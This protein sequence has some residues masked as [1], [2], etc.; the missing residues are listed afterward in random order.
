[1]GMHTNRLIYEKSPYLLQHAHNPV[2]WRPWGPEALEEARRQ[3]KPIFLSVG[4]STCHWCHVMERESFQDP[5]IAA[6]LNRHFVPIKVDREERP[7]VDRV[8]MSFVQATTG[9]G[10]W[11]LSVFL[12]PELE[13]FFG[14]TYFPPDNRYGRPGLRYV[15]ERIAEAWQADRRRVRSSGAAV[16]AELRRHW[17]AQQSRLEATETVL[18]SGFN[19]FRRIFDPTHGGFGEAPKFPRPAVLSFLLRYWERTANSEALQMALATLRAMARGGLRDQLGGGF[20]RYS[21]DDRWR[22][23][24][25]EKMLYDQAQLVVSYLEAWQAAG[26]EIFAEVARDTLEY[27][28][29]DMQHAEGG[30]CAAEDADSAVDPAQPEQK[31]EGA[32][33]VWTAAQVRSLLAEPV[34]SWFC[35]HYGVGDREAYVLAE[36]RT[37]EETAAEAGRPVEE[38]RAA[39]AE[40]RRRL[41]EARSRRPRPLRD[42]KIL[43]A[44]NGLAISA[45]ARAFQVFGEIRYLEAARRAAEFLESRMIAAGRLLR[46]YRDGEAAIPGFLEDYAFYVQGLLDL[47][48]AEFDPHRLELALRL[49]EQQLALFEDRQGGG[50]FSAADAELPLRPRDDYDGAEPSGN[51]VSVMNLLRLAAMTGRADF[52]QAAERTLGAFGRQMVRAPESLPLMLAAL[53]YYRSGLRQIVIA[54]RRDA[55]QT[56]A[57]LRVVHQRFLPGKVLLVLDQDSSRKLAVSVAHLMTEAPP[58]GAR[59]Y[60]CEDF[61]CRFPVSEPEELAQLLERR[62]GA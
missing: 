58:A 26:E 1:M 9:S 54:G 56:Q 25:F 23:P 51:S 29:R 30:F 4:Y 6:L 47:Y 7:D 55:P 17:E 18:D 41:L 11:P 2:D 60:V 27:L 28:L 22:V 3:D 16:V 44:W 45:F 32:Y 34:A 20:H 35:A 61:T 42:D 40:G 59:A 14:G 57:L 33:Y 5:S 52:H 43:T 48:E 10:G 13:P 12:T 46:R 38:V 50:F 21:V 31:E 37:L 19:A 49:T 39:L 53:A 36:V 15:L 62:S 24:H 8:Y